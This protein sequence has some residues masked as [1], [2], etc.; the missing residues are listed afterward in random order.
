MPQY[1]PSVLIAY[2]R[3]IVQFFYV[4][5]VNILSFIIIFRSKLTI[6][7]LVLRF[8]YKTHIIAYIFFILIAILS[9][10]VAENYVESIFELA[11][12][13]N[14]FFAFVAI[15]IFSSNNNIDFFK[16]FVVA[17]LLAIAIES[18]TINY[19]V[20]QAVL[21]NGDF[22]TRNNA[23]SGPGA[24]TIISAFALV[25]KTNVLLYLLLNQRTD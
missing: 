8:K 15:I 3:A 4:S 11:Q 2:D 16:Y 5:L 20:Y 1:I 24:N 14:F 6:E 17:S 13:I 12:I 9:I 7:N 21:T 23:F 18:F 19:L 25:M 10:V 22:L